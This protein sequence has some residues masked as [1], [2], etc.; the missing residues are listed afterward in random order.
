MH[1]FLPQARQE[2]VG[3]FNDERLRT[4]DERMWLALPTFEEQLQVDVGKLAPTLVKDAND[5]PSVSTLPA[6]DQPA[7]PV[8]D[9]EDLL[10]NIGELIG[11]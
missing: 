1:G 2:V 11:Q 4:Y 6:I 7:P 9:T 8:E 5:N 10:D 3:F